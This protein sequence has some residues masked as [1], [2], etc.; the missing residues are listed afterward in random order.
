VRECKASELKCAAFIVGHR[1]ANGRKP[2]AG[3]MISIK[4]LERLTGVEF[5][6][7][8]PNAPKGKAEARD[9]GL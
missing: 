8:V 7:N 3:E 9:W 1:S 5:F 4:E 2:S 6:T